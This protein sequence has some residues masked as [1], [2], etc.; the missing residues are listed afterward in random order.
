MVPDQHVVQLLTAPRRA[1]WALSPCSSPSGLLGKV[2]IRF[3]D[4]AC[5]RLSHHAPRLTSR[6][7]EQAHRRA[8]GS[9]NFADRSE[10]H[11][12]ELQSRGHLVCR[13]LLEKKK[14]QTS[15]YGCS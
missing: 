8:D 4:Q 14:T 9:A 3:R 1:R 12:S 13:L 10:E 15:K 5:R 6:G 7:P 2:L 11:T